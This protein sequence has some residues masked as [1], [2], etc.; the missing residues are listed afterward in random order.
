MGPLVSAVDETRLPTITV[1]ELAKEYANLESVDGPGSCPKGDDA[2]EFSKKL[3]QFASFYGTPLTYF[4][5]ASLPAGAVY[6]ISPHDRLHVAFPPDALAPVW[7][8]E[9]LVACQAMYVQ[10][11][12]VLRS[13]DRV[14]CMDLIFG[15]IIQLLR[16]MGNEDWLQ[17]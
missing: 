13:N 7:I 4:F 2:E 9:Q 6:T 1:I 15:I 5:C 11:R 14:I 10:I 17:K 8:S 16:F 3:E 12:E